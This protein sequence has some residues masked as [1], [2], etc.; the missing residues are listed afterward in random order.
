MIL[1][2]IAAFSEEVSVNRL[3]DRSSSIYTVVLCWND[4]NNLLDKWFLRYT[5]C[6]ILMF[7]I[8]DFY[9]YS[10]IAVF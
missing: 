2:K 5:T 1:I 10:K 9:E 4:D 3:Y 8:L 7:A 6:S